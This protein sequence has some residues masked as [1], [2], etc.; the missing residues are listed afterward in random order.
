MK[1][2]YAL[3]ACAVLSGCAT[4]KGLYDW[5]GYSGL[6]Y[7]SYKDPA[8]IAEN[9]HKLEANI[10]KAEQSGAKVA[11]GLYADLGTMLLQSG[12][13]DKAVINFQKER[14]LWPESAVL[15]DAMIKNIQPV[16]QESKS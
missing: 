13:R 12:D 9:M 10:L 6:L 16:K 15:M 8:K 5:S 4:N 14:A 1:I 2:V 7:Q 3:I 11:P